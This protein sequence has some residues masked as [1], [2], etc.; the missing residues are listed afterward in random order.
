MRIGKVDNPIAVPRQRAA[1]QP[2]GQRPGLL[3]PVG[4]EVEVGESED[5]IVEFVGGEA[6]RL[7]ERFLGDERVDLQ[8]SRRLPG[9][10][11]ARADPPSMAPD[12]GPMTMKRPRLRGTLPEL[13]PEFMAHDNV[14]QAF[15]PKL[16]EVYPDFQIW[17]VDREAQPRRAIGYACS[18]P[19][20]FTNPE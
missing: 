19:V 6:V 10:D 18:V 12:S 13:W 9:P 11:P 16:Y 20:A 17:V 15:W 7:R 8:L 5:R 1:G 4:R 3:D 2:L 14:V